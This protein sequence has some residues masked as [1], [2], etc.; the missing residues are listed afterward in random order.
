MEFSGQGSDWMEGVISEAQLGSSVS[1]TQAGS[2]ARGR[3]QAAVQWWG[4]C[5]AVVAQDRK[6]GG[7]Q[8]CGKAEGGVQEMNGNLL[9]GTRGGAAL[10]PVWG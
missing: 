8:P 4:A 9:V 1:G 7:W 2:G 3:D 10:T 6:A 5:Q